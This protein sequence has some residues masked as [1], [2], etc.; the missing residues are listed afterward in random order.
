MTRACQS[1]KWALKDTP[2]GL[3][4]AEAGMLVCGNKAIAKRAKF[5]FG[6]NAFEIAGN[7]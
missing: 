4:E 3:S 6:W 7:R 2:C 5:T 1:S